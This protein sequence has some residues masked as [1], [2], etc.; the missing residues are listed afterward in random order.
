MWVRGQDEN[1]AIIC[2]GWQ[3]FKTTKS[4]DMWSRIQTQIGK[5]TN[6]NWQRTRQK[7][8]ENKFHPKRCIVK[9]HATN[10]TCKSC[11]YRYQVADVNCNDQIK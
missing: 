2:K 9:S 11:I 3:S 4:R 1:T 5:D 7:R 8:E 6:S 10:V